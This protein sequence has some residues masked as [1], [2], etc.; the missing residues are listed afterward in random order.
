M[1]HISIISSSIRNGRKS[2]NVAL[3]LQKYVAENQLATAEI[4]DL[5]SYNFP[6]FEERLQFQEKPTA[7]T[8][9][10]AEKIKTSDGI[11][12]VTPEYNGGFPASL[13]NVIDLL[14]AEWEGKPIGISTVSAGGYAGSQA[15]IFLQF[16]LWKIKAYTIP[17]TFPIAKVQEQFDDFGN[18]VLKAETDKLASVFIKELLWSIK[19]IKKESYPS[20]VISF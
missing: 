10:F 3:Y 14:Y 20:D 16:V 12:I 13:K 8:L 11:I 7:G 2:H 19:L 15:L 6:V 17:A 18:A 5:K 4:L 9:E 1:Y